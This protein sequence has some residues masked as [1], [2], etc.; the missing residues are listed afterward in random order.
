MRY[1]IALVLAIST[2]FAADRSFVYPGS[3]SGVY[4]D[5]RHCPKYTVYKPGPIDTSID[6]L[7]SFW[8]DTSLHTAS[9]AD[10]V[11]SGYDRGHMAPAEDMSISTNS[12][13]YS[14]SMA[15]ACPQTPKLNRGVMV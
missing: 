12:M 7:S 4:N 3:Y 5:S 6:R 2:V 13:Y 9:D 1:L 11:N 8:R 14:F 15:N 10:Y